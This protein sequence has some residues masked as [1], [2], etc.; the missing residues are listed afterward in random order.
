MKSLLRTCSFLLVS[1]MLFAACNQAGEAPSSDIVLADRE[2]TFQIEGM[3]CEAG[4]KKA[5]EKVLKNAPGVVFGEVIFDQQ[6]A[7]V[8]YDSK[9]TSPEALMALINESYN[10]SYQA[11]LI[12]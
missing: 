2:I 4:C 3:T 9:S 11:S 10:G 7:F 1:I 6:Q 8:K 12:D 5:V